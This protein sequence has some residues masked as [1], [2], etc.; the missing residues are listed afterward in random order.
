MTNPRETKLIS[1]LPISALSV[2]FLKYPKGPHNP[3]D[4]ESRATGF[5]QVEFF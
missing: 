5:G 4:L 1:L 2:P 3:E